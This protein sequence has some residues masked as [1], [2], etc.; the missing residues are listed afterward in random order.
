MESKNIW[1]ECL[2]EIKNFIPGRSFETWFKPLQA[3]YISDSEFIFGN[4]NDDSLKDIWMGEKKKA[5][6]DKITNL[7]HSPCAEYRCRQDVMNRYLERVKNP[8]LND[9]FI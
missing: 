5:T 2:G 9:E 3:K 1:N 7:N 8:E 6:I 4:I